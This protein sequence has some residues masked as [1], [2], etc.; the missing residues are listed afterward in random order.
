MLGARKLT[1]GLAL[2]A[3]A[4]A[5][6]PAA[7]ATTAPTAVV[8]TSGPI[9]TTPATATQAP[10]STPGL[11]TGAF[12]VFQPKAGATP[13]VTGGATLVGA[14]GQTQV[15]IAVVSSSMEPMAASIQAGTCDALTPEIAYRLT[16]VKS[17]AS[18]TSVPV[19]LATLLATPYAINI[20]VAGSETES[21]ITCGEIQAGVA[22]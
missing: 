15:V 11:P 21:S 14:S 4:A 18:T 9:A 1:L 19:D 7:T 17:G 2:C 3:A 13:S 10:V 22:P 6:S 12:A 5:C 16:E 20:S 8:A